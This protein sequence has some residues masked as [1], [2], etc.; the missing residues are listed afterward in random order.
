MLCAGFVVKTVAKYIEKKNVK[1]S[2]ACIPEYLPPTPSGDASTVTR[3]QL[4]PCIMVM[5]GKSRGPGAGP[6]WARLLVLSTSASVAF[7]S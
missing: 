7:V 1:L 6:G 2:C 4:L 5:L 3:L